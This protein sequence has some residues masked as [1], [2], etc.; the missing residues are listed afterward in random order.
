MAKREPTGMRRRKLDPGRA[1]RLRKAM[2]KI[3]A[4]RKRIEEETAKTAAN[5]AAEAGKGEAWRDRNYN[6][7]DDYA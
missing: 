3:E 2:S 4:A 5:S 6:T 1:K 7:P